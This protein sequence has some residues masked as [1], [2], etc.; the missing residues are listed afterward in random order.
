MTTPARERNMSKHTPTCQEALEALGFTPEGN[1]CFCPDHF[2]GTRNHV[3]H[4]GECLEAQ[5]AIDESMKAEA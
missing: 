5:R 3:G 1:Y 2:G 4:T